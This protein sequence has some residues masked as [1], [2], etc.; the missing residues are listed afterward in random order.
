[1]KRKMRILLA[2]VG[3][4]LCAMLFLGSCED[5][6][7]PTTPETTVP[8]TQP[9]P[10]KPPHSELYI[11][12]LSVEDVIRY[13]NEVALDAEI[14]NGGD[15]SK[16]QKWGEPIY[17]LID[18]A[19]TEKDKQVLDA[20][21]LWLNTID[22]FPGISQANQVSEVNMRIYFRNN[23]GFVSLMGDAFRGCDGG[24]TFWYRDNAIYDATVCYRTDIG[25]EVRNS[26]L[27]EEIY[28]GLGPVQDT[29]LR[30]DSIIYAGYS[31]PQALT[32]IDELLLK[33]L[34]HPKMVCGMT[35]EECEAV[36]RE[37][38]Y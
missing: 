29:W 17:Y 21:F 31:T 1:M 2:V 23:K 9:Q 20:F 38:Y 24:V 18:G 32:Q 13:F 4:L 19:C 5:A 33:L 34:Y 14:V 22:G 8:E 35:A 6:P 15:P 25:Q 3:A 16:L 12:D 28:N 37:L 7:E 10:T 30:K 11:P 36:I 26:V 27:L